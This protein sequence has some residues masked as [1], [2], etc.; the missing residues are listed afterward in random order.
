MNIE[1]RYC[2]TCGQAIDSRKHISWTEAF[3]KFGYGDGDGEVYTE[4]I[5]SHIEK[6]GLTCEYAGSIHNTIIDSIK[7][8]DGKE[9]IG[10]SVETGYDCPRDYLPEYLVKYLDQTYNGES[11]V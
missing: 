11:V 7:D 3:C 6:L 4:E 8:K 10:E 2:P 9:L 5:A 1:K